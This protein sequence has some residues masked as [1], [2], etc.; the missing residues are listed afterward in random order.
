MRLQTIRAQTIDIGQNLS[1]VGQASNQ[2]TSSGKLSTL[3]QKLFK[4]LTPETDNDLTYCKKESVNDTL[5]KS[6]DER[7]SLEH[8]E[9]CANAARE[10]EAYGQFE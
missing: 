10:T 4:I 6:E 7:R 5:E 9:N 1:F 3:T 8:L 2:K